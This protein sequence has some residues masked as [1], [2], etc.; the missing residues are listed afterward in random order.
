MKMRCYAPSHEAY[1]RYGGK[2]LTVCDEWKDNFKGFREW[3]IN[4]GYEQH[5]T[6]D[7]KDNEKGY[8]LNNCRWVTYAVQERNKSGNRPPITAFGETRL[9]GEWV[10]DECCVVTA[11]GLWRRID[12]GRDPEWSIVT[13]VNVGRRRKPMSEETKKKIGKRTKQRM[14]ALQEKGISYRD[15]NGRL[16]G[17]VHLL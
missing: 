9:V 3:A 7:R 12:S 14:D 5:L 1:E 11:R 4:N 6:I 15:E 13:P 16:K 8:D 10:E 2:G 17:G